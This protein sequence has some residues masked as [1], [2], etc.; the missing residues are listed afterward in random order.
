MHIIFRGVRQLEVDHIGQ[1][2][3]IQAASGDI[4]G[5]QYAQFAFLEPRQRF[6]TRALSLVAV[7]GFGLQA[8]AL[9]F[10]RQTVGAELGLA[11]HDDL[12][13]LARFDQMRQQMALFEGIHRVNN[14]LDLIVGGVLTRDLHRLRRLHEISGQPFDLRRKSGGEQ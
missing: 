13:H 14:L 12:A 5:H 8:V 9:Q 7:N 4:G 2:R 1:L 3:H 11:K 10:T 6:Q